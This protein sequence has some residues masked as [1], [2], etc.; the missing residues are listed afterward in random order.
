MP[1]LKKAVLEERGFRPIFLVTIVVRPP[2]L[3]SS[4]RFSDV[5]QQWQRAVNNEVEASAIARITHHV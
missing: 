5:Q 2:Q 4:P 3:G 1:Q